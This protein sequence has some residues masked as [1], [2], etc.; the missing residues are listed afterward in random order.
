MQCAKE[1]NSIPIQLPALLCLM[2]MDA[3][4]LYQSEIKKALFC[5]P[6]SLSSLT[7]LLNF[8]LSTAL[9]GLLLMLPVTP[10]VDQFWHFNLFQCHLA[11]EGE[12]E[13]RKEKQSHVSK[14]HRQWDRTRWNRVSVI[15]EICC[16]CCRIYW[17]SLNDASVALPCQMIAHHYWAI[18][19]L[20][21]HLPLHLFTLR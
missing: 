19:S 14:K 7:F 18:V 6:F 11:N 20:T 5:L 12:R 21:D 17:L 2:I 9:F 10:I 1:N 15:W 4:N 8:A 13:G 3:I 16:C